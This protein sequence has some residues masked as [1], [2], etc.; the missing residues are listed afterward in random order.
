MNLAAG[1]GG[2]RAL[3]YSRHEAQQSGQVGRPL[4]NAAF[5]KENQRPGFSKQ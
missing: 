1:V 2:L 4:P 5:A 3:S